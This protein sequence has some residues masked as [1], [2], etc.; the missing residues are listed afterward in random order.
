M[1]DEDDDVD[2]RWFEGSLRGCC[3]RVLLLRK[4]VALPWELLLLSSSVWGGNYLCTQSSRW[5]GT[6]T[7][8]RC[9]CCCQLWPS[10]W[11]WGDMKG[12]SMEGRP[13][14]VDWVF[15]GVGF[16][17]LNVSA[18]WIDSTLENYGEEQGKGMKIMNVNFEGC[19]ALNIV[20]TKCFC[21]YLFDRF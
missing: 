15:A 4:F 17:R 14:M 7:R 13:W 8:C 19:F 5:K 3:W 1:G 16:V 2:E 11:Q 12:T 20:C 6:S 21:E 18:V 9:C 10:A